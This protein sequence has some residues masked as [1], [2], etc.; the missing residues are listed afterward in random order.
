METQDNSDCIFCGIA[1]GQ[2]PADVIK[3]NGNAIYFR[4][5]NPKARVHV[6]AIPKKHF[7]SLADVTEEDKELVGSMLHG[8]T[9]IAAKEELKESGYRVISNVGL[10]AG[11]DVKHLHFH[12]LGGEPLG[13]L[14]C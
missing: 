3:E 4:D 11:Q 10:D 2:T 12:L 1:S 14:K 9:E 8:L 5:I 6:L 7:T 13:P